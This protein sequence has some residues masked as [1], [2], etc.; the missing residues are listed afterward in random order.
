MK[1]TKN[2]IRNKWFTGAIKSLLTAAVFAGTVPASKAESPAHETRE[3][4]RKLKQ[5]IQHIIVI[6]QENWSFDS[7]YGQFPGVNGLQ[8]AF[9]TLPQLDKS[10]GYSNLLYQTPSPLT[11]SPP[12]ADP[13]FPRVSGSLAL[14]SNT[15]QPLPLIP[16]D[17]TKY[18]ASNAL[19][20]DIIHRFYHEQLQ[21]DNGALEPKN[22]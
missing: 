4:D 1:T 8:N 3:L 19:T 9:D 22:G 17:F 10:S 15:N 6:Y 16:Y 21:I 5:K 11:G 14:W 13:Q 18:V 2:K 20:G 12:A 7:L